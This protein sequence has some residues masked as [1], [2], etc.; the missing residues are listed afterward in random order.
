MRRGAG[1]GRKESAEDCDVGVE[2]FRNSFHILFN[3]E[4]WMFFLYS[5]VH[6]GSDQG[7]THRRKS[8]FLGFNVGLQVH[9]P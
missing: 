1:G 7:R 2:L 3:L 8:S 9:H 6:I 5:R 4:V